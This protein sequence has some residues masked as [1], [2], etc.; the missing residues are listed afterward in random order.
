[1]DIFLGACVAALV[2]YYLVRALS[3]PL[4]SLGMVLVRSVVAFFLIW[5]V[6]V[7]GSF[8]GFHM[9]LNAVSCLTVGLLGFPGMALLIAVKYLL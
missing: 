9:G 6:N 4:R 1:M 3:R 5:A 8:F 2:G 7:I